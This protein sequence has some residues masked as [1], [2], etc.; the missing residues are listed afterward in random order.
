MLNLLIQYAK[1][2][3]LATEPGFKPK[4]VR[5]AMVFDAAGQFL[6]VQ[7]LGDLE[8]K[9]NPGRAF[10]VCPDLSQPELKSGGAGCR[11]FLVDTTEVVALLSKDEPD[12]KLHAKHAYFVN[13]LRQA[14]Q[15]MPELAGMAEGLCDPALLARV[16]EQFLADGRKALPTDTV[17]PAVMENGQ[18]RFPVESSAWHDWWRGFRRSLSAG[19]GRS[20][21][22]ADDGAGPAASPSLMRCLISGELVTPVLTQPKIEGLSDVGGLAMG[23]S[24]ASYKQ[25][26]FRSF[27]L[28]QSLN[29][30]MSE[31]M[32]SAYRLALNH[33]IRHNSVKLAGAKVV[34]WYAGPKE[35]PPEE[36]PFNRLFEG[37]DF[38]PAKADAAPDARTAEPAARVQARHLLESIRTS[39][40][41]DVLSYRYY[42]LTL[43]GAGG[44]VMVRD[45]MEGQFEDLAGNIDAW[46]DDLAIVHRDGKGLAPSPW[47]LAVLEAMVR[48]RDDL[49]APLVAKMW[50]VAVRREPI[51]LQVMAQ[52][53]R[54]VH[55]DILH[56]QLFHP[57]R[58]G[59]LKAYRIRMSTSQFPKG[60]V[61][62]K[63]CLNEEHP[64]P[65]YHC[66][67]LLAVLADLQRAALGDVG[68][69]VVQRYYAA[70]ST[71]PALVLGR[72]TALSQHHLNKLEPGLAH[73]FDSRIAGIWGRIESG[74]PTVLPLEEQSLF[75]LGYYQ[76]KAQR[77]NGSAK[78]GADKPDVEGP[79]PQS[80]TI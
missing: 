57:A 65:A 18:L 70:A 35:I 33:L 52:V 80:E 40:R 10:A 30:A 12:A 13:L 14:S 37:M 69:G 60:D 6:G 19:R 75:A 28:T 21:A 64:S 11:H 63:P 34:H 73:W 23:D 51:P 39:Q 38:A 36:D 46:F 50:R 7:E 32:A 45:W 56:D 27:G 54:R 48:V 76:Q 79:I 22:V 3:G 9:R 2:H 68:A 72:L 42:A 49:N 74:I 67:R 78:S 17:T 77:A 44:R 8:A 59:L 24:L 41:A 31:E 29:A 62:M 61:H 58:L 47:F 53:L 25:D 4:T 16:R 15:A 20:G 55:I 71:T 43:S 1:D 26:S 5:W 66:G